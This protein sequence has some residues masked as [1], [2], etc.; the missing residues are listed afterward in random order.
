MLLIFLGLYRYNP[1]YCCKQYFLIVLCV[2]DTS[3]KTYPSNLDPFIS[4]NSNKNLI[5]TGIQIY[6]ILYTIK[7]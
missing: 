7:K 4:P 5:G 6:N 2:D 1:K 3:D